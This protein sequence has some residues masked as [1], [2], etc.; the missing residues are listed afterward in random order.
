MEDEE[1]R[2][3]IAMI[4]AGSVGGALLILGVVLVTC[5]HPKNPDES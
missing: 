2:K 4:I 5:R 3:K 1:E